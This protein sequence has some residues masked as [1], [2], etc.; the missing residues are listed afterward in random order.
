MSGRVQKRTDLF[1][2]KIASPQGDRQ[3]LELGPRMTAWPSYS[4]WLP[5]EL[6]PQGET[7]DSE[8][9]VPQGA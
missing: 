9:R 7:E 2:R 5:R 4:T 3:T 1:Q 6:S 8:P